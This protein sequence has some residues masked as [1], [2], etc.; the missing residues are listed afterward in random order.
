[1][2]LPTATSNGAIQPGDYLTPSPVPGVAMRAIEAGPVIGTA[3]EGLAT[4]SGRI[5]AFIH[6]GHYTPTDGVESARQEFAEQIEERTADPETGI[7]SMSGH[8]QVVLDKDAN[9]EARFSIFRDGDEGLG[10]EVFRVDE[11]GN[12]FAGGSF[13]PNA[14][15]LA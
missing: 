15:D 9:D 13:R 8:L 10:A 12:V 14:M 2:T 1:M 7:Q 6:R 5:L 3:M 4:G 11:S